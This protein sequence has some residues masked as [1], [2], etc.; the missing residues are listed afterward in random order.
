MSTQ[1]PAPA[2]PTEDGGCTTP[3]ATMGA[4][5]QRYV[6][7]GIWLV[8]LTQTV[9]GVDKHSS[10][11]A[12]LAGYVIVAAF[13]A[14]YVMALPLGW[15]GHGQ[16]RVFW[17]LYTAGFGLTIAETFFA[18]QTALAFCIYLSVLTVAANRRWS[19]GFV[20]VIAVTCAVLPRVV[21]GWGGKIDWDDGVTMLLVAFA[22][23]GFF[24]IIRSNRE[25]AA[26]RA[27]V[28]RLAAE[29][30]RSRIARDLHDLL[31]HSLTTITVKAGLARRLAERNDPRALAEITE[32]ETLSRRTLGDVRAAVAGHREVT[33]AGEIATAREVLRAAGILAELPGSVDVVD[34]ELSELFGWV[35]R[36]GI[37]NV[38]RHS[39][40]PSCRI[41]LGARWIEIADNGSGPTS[42][43]GGSGL[44][45]LT[46]RLEAVGGTLTTAGGFNGF[47]LRAEVPA[48]A[49][50]SAVDGE[51]ADGDAGAGSA[52][53]RGAGPGVGPGFTPG[54][55]LRGQ[56]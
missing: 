51:A 22:M 33:L 36:E 10:G 3:A 52:V 46:E 27:E 20:V 47:R 4:G 26:A 50:G 7:P 54:V 40:S 6:F 56:G 49:P 43:P 12:A 44:C 29:G 37:T 9:A 48:P 28:A 23:F 39:H 55:V 24:H 25:L 53:D 19:F 2:G 13:C 11:T 30:E 42:E 1:Q 14:V 16:R 15:H 8:Y 34:P 38:V 31:G 18:H 32:V 35:V 45:G 5:W 17:V 41:A 21:P